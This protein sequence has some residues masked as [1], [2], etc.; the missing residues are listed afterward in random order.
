MD[1]SDQKVLTEFTKQLKNYLK[2][3]NAIY[4]KI[5]PPIMYQEI[6]EEANK[7]EGGNNNYK[8]FQ[9]CLY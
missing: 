3:E 4:L 6:D 8:I 2:K 5:D 9:L 1:F 7:I